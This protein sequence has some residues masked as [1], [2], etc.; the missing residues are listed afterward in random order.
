MIAGAAPEKQ[1]L[2][3]AGQVLADDDTL[4]HYNISSE[5]TVQ[6]AVRMG[7]SSG[8]GGGG[9]GSGGGAEPAAAAA[10]EAGAGSSDAAGEDVLAV[11]DVA[12]LKEVV[13]H[14]ASQLALYVV[15]CG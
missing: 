1:R 9:G 6:L 13:A 4:K 8:G 3:F 10:A 14:G 2:I 15:E 11:S 7:D 5:H 12:Q